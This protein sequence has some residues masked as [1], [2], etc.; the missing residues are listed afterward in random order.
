MNSDDSTSTEQEPDTPSPDHSS[1]CSD[2]HANKQ[3]VKQRL[4]HSKIVFKVKIM[5]KTTPKC[6]QSIKFYDFKVSIGIKGILLT[7]ATDTRGQNNI[8]PKLLQL[9]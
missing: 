1:E 9:N 3:F 6:I 8:L 2:E 5:R 4:H 7:A